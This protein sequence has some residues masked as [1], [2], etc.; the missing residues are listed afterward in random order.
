MHG[1]AFEGQPNLLRVMYIIIA[2]SRF[3]ARILDGDNFALLYILM[4]TC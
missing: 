4:A 3:I 2:A 1:V